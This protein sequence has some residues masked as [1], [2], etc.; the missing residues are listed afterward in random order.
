METE[1]HREV[2]ETFVQISGY[3][4]DERVRAIFIVGSSASGQGD[5]YS[6]VDVM[7]VVN[8]PIH[9]NERLRRLRAIGCRNIMLTI[10]GVD[11]P[12]LP[13]Q[14]QVIDKFVFRDIWF[15]V[16]YHLPHQLQFCFDY[17]TLVDKD[18]LTPRLCGTNRVYNNADLK[19]RAR[20]DLRL[21]HARIY[22]YDKYCRRGEWVGLDLSAVKNLLVD[23]VMTLND[24]PDYNRHSSRISQ[25]LRDLLVKPEHFD[26]DLLDILHLDNRETWMRKVEMLRRM[27]ADLI[28]LCEVRW[29]P[30]AMF[31]DGDTAD[32]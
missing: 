13:V 12:A 2:A 20:A 6:D 31:D 22:R 27:E 7:M 26:R 19:A 29:G 28:A 9:D 16:S 30:I 10:A 3:A 5:A 21:L 11:N 8:T 14:S 25:L 4:D 17:V 24:Q 15:D 32:A 23:L 1:T 18:D